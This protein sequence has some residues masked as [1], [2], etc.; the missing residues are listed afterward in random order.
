[1]IHYDPTRLAVRRL[2]MLETVKFP[3]GISY[4][5]ASLADVDRDAFPLMVKCKCKGRPHNVTLTMLR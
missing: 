4:L 2:T 5:G 3:T 1:M